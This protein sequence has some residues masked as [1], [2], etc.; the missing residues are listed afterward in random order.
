MNHG[1]P[2]GTAH[3]CSGLSEK[4][5]RS[6]AHSAPP[7]LKRGLWPPAEGGRAAS[8]PTHPRQKQRQGRLGC[9]SAI[10]WGRGK[11]TGGRAG[12]Q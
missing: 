4:A 5:R 6:C 8:A 1:D 9:R 12:E 2:R 10:Q 3:L 7:P 11:T